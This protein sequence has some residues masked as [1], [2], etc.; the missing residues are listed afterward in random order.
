MKDEK[1]KDKM[2]VGIVIALLFGIIV[3][4]MILGLLLAIILGT[5]IRNGGKS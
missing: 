3:H 2:I 5:F 1:I 4:H